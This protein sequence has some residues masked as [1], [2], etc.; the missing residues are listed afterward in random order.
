MSNRFFYVT[1]FACLRIFFLSDV[2]GPHIEA[3]LQ[4]AL[5]RAVTDPL[6]AERDLLALTRYSARPEPY[7]A[8]L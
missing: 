2:L 5:N 7:Q 6:D 4:I 1:I 8:L 3:L